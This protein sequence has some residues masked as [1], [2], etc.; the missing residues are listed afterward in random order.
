MPFFPLNE[1][2]A[3]PRVVVGRGNRQGVQ[4][5]AFDVGFDAIAIQV[6]LEKMIQGRR[7]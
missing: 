5:P 6:L 1:Q 3:F 4:K 2:V 7:I